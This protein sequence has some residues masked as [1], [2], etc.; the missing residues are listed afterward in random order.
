M[1][2]NWKWE[3]ISTFHPLFT[4][5]CSSSSSK[6]F[7]PVL[8]DIAFYPSRSSAHLFHGRPMLLFPVGF[9]LLPSLSFMFLSFLWY[10]RFTH[11]FLFLIHSVITQISDVLTFNPVSSCLFHD[12]WNYKSNFIIWMTLYVWFMLLICVVSIWTILL[13]E[14]F[15]MNFY[16][17]LQIFAALS[18]TVSK[19]Q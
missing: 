6:A 15:L 12:Y 14:W 5:S 19:I 16:E 3:W 11:L 10:V 8:S 18:I 9:Y 17:K 2:S 1:C 13:D 7:L 4:V